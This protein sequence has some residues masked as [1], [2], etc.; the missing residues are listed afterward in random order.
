[1]KKFIAWIKGSNRW[2]H[3]AGGLLIGLFASGWYCA[4]YTS[5]IAGACLEYKDRAYGGKW[6]WVDLGLTV[7]GAALGHLPRLFLG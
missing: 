7:G 5:V 2:K 6:D 1:M 3:L 4:A